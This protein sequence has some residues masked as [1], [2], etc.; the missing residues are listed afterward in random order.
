MLAAGLPLR[1]VAL[2]APGS[3]DTH[4]GQPAPLATAA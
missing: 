4:A 2:T 3:Y 1:V